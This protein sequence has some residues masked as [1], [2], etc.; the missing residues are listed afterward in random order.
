VSEAATKPVINEARD[1]VRLGDFTFEFD[2]NF[3]QVVVCGEEVQGFAEVSPDLW[4][5]FVKAVERLAASGPLLSALQQIDQLARDSRPTGGTRAEKRK[6]FRDRAAQIVG[7]VQGIVHQVLD[8]YER[9][10]PEQED[11]RHVSMLE[12]GSSGMR[13]VAPEDVLFAL[14][15]EADKLGAEVE[16]VNWQVTQMRDHRVVF[17]YYY[18]RGEADSEGFRVAVHYDGHPVTS[19]ELEN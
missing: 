15:V 4:D 1:E 3:I 18:Y 19:E 16:A 10:S 17:L 12:A 9:T 11:T 7:R 14:N 2:S 5:G 13:G 6:Q 8:E